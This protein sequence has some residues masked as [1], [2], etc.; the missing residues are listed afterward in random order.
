MRYAVLY[1]HYFHKLIPYDFDRGV[2]TVYFDA[3]SK[4]EALACDSTAVDVRDQLSEIKAPDAGNRRTI[5]SGDP[6]RSVIRACRRSSAIEAGD[7]GAQRSLPFF[8]EN[9]LF[10]EWVR[11]Y[12]GGIPA[13]SRM[14]GQFPVFLPTRQAARGN[15]H[16]SEASWLHLCS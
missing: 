12:H 4:K 10:T 16:R 14:T 3:L 7:D 13:V 5:R 6:T 1:P 8:E 9:Y 15:G 11:Q 2:Y